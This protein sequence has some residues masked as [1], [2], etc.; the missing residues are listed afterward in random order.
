MLAIFVF[1]I[2]FKKSKHPEKTGNVVLFSFPDY[3]L[4]KI[5]TSV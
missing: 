1:F 2:G 3:I 5:K 4:L